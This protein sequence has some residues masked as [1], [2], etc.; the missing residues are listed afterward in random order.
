MYKRILVPLDGSAR[1]EQAIPIA[2][3]IAHALGDSV[4]LLRVATAP[5]DTG[6]YSTTSGYVEEAVDADLAA[7]YTDD[8]EPEN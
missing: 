3:R 6:K 8:H 2:A 5:V 4:I 1:A 7:A